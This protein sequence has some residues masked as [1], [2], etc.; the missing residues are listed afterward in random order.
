MKISS[1]IERSLCGAIFPNR[2]GVWSRSNLGTGARSA[3]GY[4]L[5]PGLRQQRGQRRNGHHNASVENH[6][7]SSWTPTPALLNPFRYTVRSSGGNFQL[8]APWVTSKRWSH[9][10]GEEGEGGDTSDALDSN[11]QNLLSLVEQSENASID[12]HLELIR[13][14][15]MRRYAQADGPDLAVSDRPDDKDF[16]SFYE[17]REGGDHEQQ[18]IFK[19]WRAVQRR[20]R[21]PYKTDIEYIY[22]LYQSL[23]EPRM[24]YLH[25]KIRHGLMRCLGREEKNSKSMLR[26]FAVVADIQ[27]SGLRLTR[28][29]W[30]GA[31]S[32][33]ARY[34][35]HSTET[36]AAAT[37]KLWREME[38][39]AGIKS[40]AVTFNILFD[41]ASKAGNFVLSEML[42][43]E[44]IRRGLKFDRY[45]HV[46]LIHFFGL[47]M[48]SDGIRAAYKEM[49]EDGEMIDTTV[50]NCVIA[51]F[52]RCGEEYA[53][54]RVYERMKAAHERAPAMP[55]RNYMNDKIITKT[56]M[57]FA[58]ISKEDSELR[59]RFQ[60]VSPIVPDIQT[61]RIL[62]NHHAVKMAA[63]DKVAL[64]LTDM[65]WFHIPL[66]GAIFL[67]LF[68]GFAF[69][70]G[71]KGQ[72]WSPQRL[73]SVWKAFSQALQENAH[74]LYVD[75]W[76]AKWI[77]RAYRK[78][79]TEDEVWE[80][81]A[82]LKPRCET[83]F[84]PE[85]LEHFEE[86]LVDLF[87]D[88]NHKSKVYSD[89]GMF[90]RVVG[91]DHG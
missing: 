54:E 21:N 91:R 74:G 50:L 62:L 78:C 70:G 24:P 6:F 18:T 32:F 57:F 38:Q 59:R 82:Q 26:Y 87:K 69:Y 34:V 65:K 25:A 66:H 27:S 1:R 89:V 49:V 47:K 64:Y 58:K 75:V 55:Y 53:A 11:K 88:D 68:K 17:V 44:M 84:D 4:Q 85:D 63:L 28:P 67:A 45:H 36:E 14:P 12:E 83:D 72:A 48:D 19:L 60:K 33:A 13:D 40:N 10:N 35:G 22:Q 42:Y 77:L 43:N 16:P 61:Y 90:G 56:L 3:H 79:G 5:R 71:P 76:L 46:S 73:D 41:V 30:N 8:L 31:L 20:L 51:G 86:F 37:M 52:F 80:V 81:W 7:F 15:Y 2:R 23:P 39:D 29:E 9:S